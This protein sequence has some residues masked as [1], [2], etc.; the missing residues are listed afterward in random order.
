MVV[1]IT[2]LTRLPLLLPHRVC[3][4]TTAILRDQSCLC[5]ILQV[6]GGI[7]QNVYNPTS[8]DQ[9]SGIVESLSA[10]ACSSNETA[11]VDCCGI[12]SCGQCI[13]P[14]NCSS[15]DMCN[16]GVID[17]NSGCCT[18]AP[19]T[20]TPIDLCHTV[21]CDPIRGCVNTNISCPVG[22]NCT[23]FSCD[24]TSG[25]CKM[26]V[27]VTGQCNTTVPGVPPP[28]PF[29]T[30]AN[31]A[32]KCND[33]NACTI[34]YCV[35]DTCLYNKTVCP[36]SDQCTSWSCDSTTGCVFT[37]TSCND[38]NACT[39]DSCDPKQGCIHTPVVCPSPNDPCKL[40]SC[41][42]NLGGC[43][44]TAVTCS[45]LTAKNCSIPACNQTCGYVSVCHPPPAFTGSEITLTEEL[46]SAIGGA[47]LVAII[48][49]GV[50]VAL[51]VAG[52][53]AYAAY[54]GGAA[55]IMAAS[56]NNPLYEP[57]GQQGTNPLHRV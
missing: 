26:T 37:N 56:A 15:P 25:S 2:S 4:G 52:G 3:S 12:C 57:T 54:G 29:C 44:E 49:A 13:L 30:P 19:V 9:L 23:S 39:I 55:P 17:V 32:T 20:C 51:G 21:T 16:T 35:Q 1:K 45:N 7:Q 48:V 11:C 41:Q 14:T 10:T 34:D 38:N 36:T 24:V 27:S 18:T 42:K 47:A 8:W 5:P 46:G 22:N 33:N 50:V 31:G 6:A 40:N 43:V 53:G 28:P